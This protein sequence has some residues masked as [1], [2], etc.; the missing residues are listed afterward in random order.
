MPDL[1]F[2]VDEN[3]Q[4]EVVE[5]LR[6][7]GWDTCSVLDPGLK[8]TEDG[9]VARICQEERRVLV[10]LDLG[11][12]DSRSYS[13]RESPGILVLKL[14]SQEK[15]HI[16]AVVRRLIPLVRGHAIGGCLWVADGRRVR[17]RS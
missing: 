5:E 8:G 3:L 15:H 17:S 11:F 10:S 13:P 1:L 12:G 9:L 14:K 6:S 7:A 16:V 2:K 4:T